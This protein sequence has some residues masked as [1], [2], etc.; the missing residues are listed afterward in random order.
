MNKNYSNIYKILIKKYHCQEPNYKNWFARTRWTAFE[1]GCLFNGIEPDE[2]EKSTTMFNNTLY[3]L[4]TYKIKRLGED[5]ANIKELKNDPQE[6]EI[7]RKA[8]PN[9]VWELK[10]HT[11]PF[12]ANECEEEIK[13]IKLF[14]ENLKAEVEAIGT[15]IRDTRGATPLELVNQYLRK[16]GD[17]P[18]KLLVHAKEGFIILHQNREIS[19]EKKK[20]WGN[21]WYLIAPPFKA[22]IKS[23][24]K[25]DISRRKEDTLL[26]L[27]G[28][29]IEKYFTGNK[30]KKDNGSYKTSTISD[31]IMYYISKQFAEV[32]IPYGFRKSN[33]VEIINNSL[34]CWNKKKE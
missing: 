30:Y 6:I 21:N 5:F 15:W 29:L 4:D 25:K 7:L 19:E 14:L 8:H 10:K 9:M 2:F 16:I 28:I 34:D 20:Y 17:I 32:D 1:A 18:N 13:Q 27:I 12:T 11:P 3:V 23:S 31:E 33:L 26:T 24:G 22:L